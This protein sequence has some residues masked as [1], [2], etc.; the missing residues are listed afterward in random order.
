[1]RISQRARRLPGAMVLAAQA[2]IALAQLE[3]Q[4]RRRGFQACLAACSEVGPMA[5]QNTEVR[6]RARWYATAI[7]R[8]ARW[9]PGTARCLQQSLVLHR[10]MHRDGVETRLQIGVL[11]DHGTFGAHAWVELDGLILNDRARAVRPFTPLR[12]HE[13]AA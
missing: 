13:V 1:M 7:E 2:W 3:F 10:W 9:Y 12:T 4:L 6:L 5:I 8:A 11:R